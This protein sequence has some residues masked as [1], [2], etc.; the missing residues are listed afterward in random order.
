MVR[1]VRGIAIEKILDFGIFLNSL[2]YFI[3]SYLLRG[4]NFDFSFIKNFSFILF[5]DLVV[6]FRV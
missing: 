6:V 2:R 3:I 4:Y 1:E 5:L